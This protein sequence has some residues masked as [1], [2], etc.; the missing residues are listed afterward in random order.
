[1]SEVKES[2]IFEEQT[3]KPVETSVEANPEPDARETICI[4]LD[5]EE[6]KSRE[7]SEFCN[8]EEDPDDSSSIN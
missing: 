6:I 2:E 7:G 8:L 3:A 1:L 4:N 5:E